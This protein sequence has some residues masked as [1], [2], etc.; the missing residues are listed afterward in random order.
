LKKKQKERAEL[1]AEIQ[2][3]SK[4]RDDFLAQEQ[5]RL[6]AGGK[7][8]SFDQKVTALI[9]AELTKKGIGSTIK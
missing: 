2:K 8:D 1:Q 6:A 4:E 9:H 3:L 5:K 7:A